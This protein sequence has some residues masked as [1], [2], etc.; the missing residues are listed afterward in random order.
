[1]KKKNKKMDGQDIYSIVE[2]PQADAPNKDG[3]AKRDKAV[4]IAGKAVIGIFC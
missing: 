2:E 1:M 4:S 3:G